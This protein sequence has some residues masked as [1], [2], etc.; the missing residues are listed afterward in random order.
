M[1]HEAVRIAIGSK[2]FEQNCKV[3]LKGDGVMELSYKTEKDELV[4]HTI[5]FSRGDVVEAKYFA[6]ADTSADAQLAE[7][8]K[9]ATSG[10]TEED[11]ELATFIAMKVDKTDQNNLKKYSNAYRPD[12]KSDEKRFVVIELRTDEDCELLLHSI[13]T[14]PQISVFF[15]EESK[16]D[17]ASVEKYSASLIL[18]AKTMAKRARRVGSAVREGFLKGRKDDDLLLTY[19]FP[20]EK[21]EFDAAAHG[22][23]ELSGAPRGETSGSDDEFSAWNTK[24]TA[25]Q[26]KED[27]ESKGRGHYLEIRVEDFDRL[28]PGEFLNDTLIDFFMKWYVRAPGDDSIYI[29]SPYSVMFSRRMTRND[30]SGTVHVFT[31][32]FFSTLEREGPSSV[33][34]WTMRKGIDI[35]KLKFVII[36]SM[37]DLFI[38]LLFVDQPGFL[39]SFRSLLSVNK[40][41]HWSICVVVN[42]GSILELI[43]RQNGSVS[44]DDEVEKPCLLFF[45]SLKC[46]QMGTVRKHVIK[47]LN[48]EWDRLG[49]NRDFSNPFQ[50]RSFN[51]LA[52]RSKF[53]FS[54]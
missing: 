45:D 19:P 7:N 23:R 5:D 39:L 33:K 2:V 50:K 42:P 44:S 8:N 10:N 43:G 3:K 48:A 4:C 52:P 34:K 46:H 29:P 22:L 27:T 24:A 25:S 47:W 36:P 21:A 26:T 20:A 30:T 6:T 35:F 54:K 13:Q 28:E 41:L 37:F 51:I 31:T 32:H 16:L 1:V 15:G 18:F 49:K 14:Y 12:G 38:V 9:N 17:I 40:N 53:F 11:F